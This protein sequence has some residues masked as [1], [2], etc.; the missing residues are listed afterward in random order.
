M[1]AFQSIPELQ[2]THPEAVPVLSL[3]TLPRAPAAKE[4]AHLEAPHHAS[5]HAGA[6]QVPPQ[7][8]NPKPSKS[9]HDSL[10]AHWH[11][12]SPCCST[13]IWPIRVCT[14]PCTW[15]GVGC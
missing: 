14:R 8:Q 13:L 15:P 10:I 6:I 1:L 2:E 11:E 3:L 7:P 12:L 9:I 5:P 4:A